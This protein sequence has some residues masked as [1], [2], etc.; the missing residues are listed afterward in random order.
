MPAKRNQERCDACGRFVP[1]CSL[2]IEDID[3]G[4]SRCICFTC[5]ENNRREAEDM[6]RKSNAGRKP[7]PA[8]EQRKQL[9]ISLSPAEADRLEQICADVGLNRSDFVRRAMA[10]HWLLALSDEQ[11][12]ALR[13]VAGIG[14]G[15]D[16]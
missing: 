7:V 5:D 10:L 6:G 13:V 11:I 14:G 8:D 16:D 12:A 9:Q 4:D 15:G 3:D 2:V 1:E